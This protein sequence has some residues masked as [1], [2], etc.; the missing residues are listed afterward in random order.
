MKIGNISNW[1]SREE[2]TTR[3]GYNELA[4]VAYPLILMSASNVVMQFAD[5]KFLGNSSTDEMAA[6]LPSGVLYFTLFCFFMVTANFTSAIVAQLHG[7]NN[8]H[9]C[10]RAAWSGFYFSILSS[11]I[12]MT[13]VPLLG[14]W[15]LMNSGNDPVIADYGWT[16][17]KSLI[18][19]G[20]FACLAA[21]F[22]AFYSG[23][24]KT[25]PVAV[26]NIGICLLNVLFDWLLIFGHWGFPKWGIFGAG[27]ATSISAGIGFFAAM[28]MFLCVNQRVYPT[29]RLRALH[30]EFIVKLL[31]FGTP[32]GLQVLS[33]LGSFTLIL[34]IVGR[35]GNE[36][37]AAMTIAFSINN[38][39]F[40]P[41]LGVSD[42]TA[43]LCGQFIGRKQ[44]KLASLIPYRSWRLVLIYAL[45]TGI[46][47]VVMPG[48]LTELFRPDDATAASATDFA[49][50]AE[51]SA[52][53]LMMAAAWNLADT[54]KFVFGGALRGAGDTRAV[55]I[56]NSCCAWL[57]ALPGIAVIVF[58]I[59][60]HVA[61]VWAY[62][63]FVTATEGLLILWRYRSGK[64]RKIHLVRS[65]L[66]AKNQVPIEELE[67]L[68]L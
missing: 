46:I 17:F 63:I 1:F 36:P 45:C 31:K 14:Y 54:V 18:P 6:A 5:R 58:W 41:L 4:R 7:S 25:L 2:F 65:E 23:R 34:L 16:Y 56:I 60:P 35:L 19:S 21:P 44:K 57:L 22:F 20:V 12:I 13:L 32:A 61:W 68:P 51:L 55:L 15:I 40:M 53:V 66:N 37:L 10:V 30:S 3:G 50:V 64:W 52:I 42:A 47:Y 11:A 28:T 29:R 59:K 38:L 9:D 67:H 24:G 48:A 39:S 27:L 33:D 8:R 62:L 49:R 26:I 43:I